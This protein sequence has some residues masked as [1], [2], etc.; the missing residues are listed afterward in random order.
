[1]FENLN[2][3]LKNRYSLY[4]LLMKVT[5]SCFLSGV[6]F[7]LVIW[8]GVWLQLE[9]LRIGGMIACGVSILIGVASSL[10]MFSTLIFYLFRNRRAK[11]ADG[12]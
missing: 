11:N 10:A 12:N 2:N 3:E 5:V 8:V 4:H 9:W 7:F 6:I 1:M